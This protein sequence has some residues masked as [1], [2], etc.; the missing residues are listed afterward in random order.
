MESKH[1]LRR[2]LA[3]GLFLLAAPAVLGA[4][5]TGKKPLDHDA[6]DIWRSVDGTALSNNG[7]WIAFVTSPREGDGILTLRSIGGGTPQVGEIERASA[8]RIT[9]DSRFLVFTIDP[10]FSVVDSLEG[11]GKK[12]DDLP[13]DSLGVVQLS[14]AFGSDGSIDMHFFKAER[15]KSWKMPADEGAYLAYTLEKAPAPPDS[16]A[17]GEEAQAEE[18]AAAGRAAGGRAGGA[19]PG[20]ARAGGGEAAGGG[21]QAG[22]EADDKKKAEGDT[23]V[24]RY[25]ASGQ[26]TRFTDVTN[27]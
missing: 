4:Q 10:M 18:P 23:L 2:S 5:A 9:S 24:F 22:G 17:E 26:E 1:A 16:T 11:E 8:P 12:G 7:T 15:I 3:M 25:L 6:Y 27:Y 14:S 20:G 13:K 19:R 21:G